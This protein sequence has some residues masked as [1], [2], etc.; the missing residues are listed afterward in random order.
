VA[1]DLGHARGMGCGNSSTASGKTTSDEAAVVAQLPVADANL[2]KHA[3]F[4][5]SKAVDCSATLAKLM[6]K[7][8]RDHQLPGYDG[9]SPFKI[10]TNEQ[11]HL[12]HKRF[13]GEG[14]IVQ[15][16]HAFAGMTKY[17][18]LI[19]AETVAGFAEW[20]G[21]KPCQ[22]EVLGLDEGRIWL[23]FADKVTNDIFGFVKTLDVDSLKKE[24]H[25]KIKAF[26]ELAAKKGSINAM[27]S[28]G[29]IE[30]SHEHKRQWYVK[31]AE[32]GHTGAMIDL[33]KECETDP[34]KKRAWYMKAVEK[35]NAH[36]MFNLGVLDGDSESGREW[37]RKAA[38][39][40]DT[41]AMFNLGNI[42]TDPI[43]Q[44][45][46]YVKSAEK[47]HAGALYN[48][49]VDKKHWLVAGEKR[50]EDAE[51]PLRSGRRNEYGQAP[52]LCKPAQVMP[53][54]EGKP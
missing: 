8:C 25:A 4:L 30:V 33:G 18:V 23:Y 45:E 12:H 11:L 44:R 22:H 29:F 2:A 7:G 27:H 32:G 39:K 34:S 28:L 38:E 46:W 5:T 36:A 48:L 16:Y 1:Q 10:V 14:K 52:Q 9:S 19:I 49:G 51:A 6:E 40:G 50:E 41:D 42:D 43:R 47:G 13:G 3:D 15:E 37:Y 35:G 53:S 26:L 17:G 20:A 24:E 31:A 54:A 21:H